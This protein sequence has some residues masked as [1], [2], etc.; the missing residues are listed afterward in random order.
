MECPCC[1]NEDVDRMLT[2]ERAGFEASII[3]RSC[4]RQVC[5]IRDEP[6]EAVDEA[7]RLFLEGKGA[8]G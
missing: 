1:G 4:D 5:V 7:A 2:H 8:H 3:C 6:G